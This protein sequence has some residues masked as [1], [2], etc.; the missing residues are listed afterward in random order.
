MWM[1]DQQISKLDN[2]QIIF[3]RTCSNAIVRAASIS[4]AGSLRRRPID[5]D[6]VLAGAASVGSAGPGSKPGDGFAGDLE[7][8]IIFGVPSVPFG[9]P[10][11]PLRSI[12]SVGVEGER[13]DRA[14]TKYIYININQIKKKIT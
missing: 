11:V 2:T 1:P 5:D 14:H 3:I 4:E 10:S 7:D 8:S 6:R 13:E 9:C 12:G